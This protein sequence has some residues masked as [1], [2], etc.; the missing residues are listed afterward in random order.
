M[1]NV[2]NHTQ[3]SG[4]DNN[5]RFDAAGNQVNGQFGQITSARLER[6]MQFALRFEF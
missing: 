4:V 6:Q 5:A 2:F 3:W 1:Y